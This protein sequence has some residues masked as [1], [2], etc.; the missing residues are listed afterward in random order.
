M[1]NKIK[2]RVGYFI[3][4]F[5]LVFL[6]S[7][8]G[9]L[10]TDSNST[11]YETTRPDLTPPNFVFP[12]VWTTLYI[13]IGISI[14]LVLLSPKNKKLIL[15]LFSLNLILNVFWSLFFFKLQSPLIAFFIL[16][17]IWL[18]TI[19]LIFKSFKTNKISSYLLIPYFIWISFA[20]VLN[21]L[22]I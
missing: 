6:T 7:F 15:G 12:I 4:A 13:L 1:K 8:I 10:L 22:A 11:W 17:L 16:I 2:K 3:L 21:Y 19:A 18:S 5:S 20:G 9:S 14:Y